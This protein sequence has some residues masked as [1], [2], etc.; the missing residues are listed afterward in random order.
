MLEIHVLHRVHVPASPSQAGVIGTISQ[1]VPAGQPKKCLLH[2]LQQL[3]NT[4]PIFI[5]P[6][7]IHQMINTE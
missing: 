6:V 4:S 1:E 7:S 5:G 3:L 2:P